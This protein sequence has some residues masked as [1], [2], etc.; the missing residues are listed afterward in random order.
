MGEILTDKDELLFRQVPKEWYQNGTLLSL[1]F[2]P[3]P[4]KDEG[5]LS[6]DRES[7]T[8]AESSFIRF[9]ESGGNTVAVFGLTVQE[10][11]D[12]KIPCF[13]DPVPD[14]PS[15]AY[16][17]FSAHSKGQIK[18]KSQRLRDLAVARGKIYPNS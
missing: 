13:G 6:G 5:R 12:H 8:T 9:K 7:L 3:L 14:N 16:A 4:R 17:D 18:K 1:A 15:H 10:F 2:R 11:D